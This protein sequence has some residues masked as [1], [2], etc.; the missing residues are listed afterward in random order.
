MRITL[1]I[2]SA[3]GDEL[4]SFV[5][6][7]QRAAIETGSDSHIDPSTWVGVQ[8]AGSQSWNAQ[9]PAMPADTGQAVM[10]KLTAGD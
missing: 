4:R 7:Y 9:T 3:T 1:A 5:L 8:A 6:A 10:R 2:D